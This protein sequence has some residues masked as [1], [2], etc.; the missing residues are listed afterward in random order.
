MR[1][2]GAGGQKRK[3]EDDGGAAGVSG[4]GATIAVVARAWVTPEKRMR[5]QLDLIIS[6]QGLDGQDEKLITMANL[7][8]NLEE[9][10][11]ML[12]GDGESL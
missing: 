1:N 9:K 5:S 8:R 7:A 11:L 10:N 12:V 2:T 4:S 6:N 3:A